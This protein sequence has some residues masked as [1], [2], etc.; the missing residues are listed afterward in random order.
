MAPLS[1]YASILLLLAYEI[2]LYREGYMSVVGVQVLHVRAW[3]LPFS[4][5]ARID[6]I[7]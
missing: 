6:V 2:E 3:V 1:R 7:K 5:V 4:S